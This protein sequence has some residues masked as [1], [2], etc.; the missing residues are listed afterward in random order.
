[1]PDNE[2]ILEAIV[3]SRNEDGTPHIAPFG[4]REREGRILI[5]P[6]RPSTSLSN[7]LARKECVLNF[8]D[9]VRV[10]AGA[11][12]GRRNW[13][14]KPSSKIEG[15][16]LESAL[17]HQELVLDEVVEDDVRPNLFFKKIHE[18][19]HQAFRGF[20]R[21]QAAVVELAVLVSRLDRL[22]LEKITQEIQYL[23]IAI[24]KTA[25]E[26]EWEAW[27]W[28]MEKVNMHKQ[29]LQHRWNNDPQD[30]GIARA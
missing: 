16:V 22:P 7:M 30:Q 12:T 6:F 20:N 23:Q 8:T 14:V 5:A 21:A 24:E 17:S 25:G 11:L 29:L 1:M 10:F 9:D 27:G 26:R 13:P 19:H 2:M 4:V 15:F 18:A 3:I 28:L